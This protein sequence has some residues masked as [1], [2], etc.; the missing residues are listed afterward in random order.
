MH[1]MM[2]IHT[3]STVNSLNYIQYNVL[4]DNIHKNCI[5]ILENV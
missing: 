3:Q 1:V 5:I 2:F 4:M